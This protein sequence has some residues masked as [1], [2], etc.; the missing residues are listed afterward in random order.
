[1]FPKVVNGLCKTIF[2]ESFIDGKRSYKCL[3]DMVSGPHAN[4]INGS[5]ISLSTKSKF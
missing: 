5:F 4:E 1:M 3:C 2:N